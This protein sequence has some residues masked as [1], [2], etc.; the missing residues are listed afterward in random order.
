MNI[1]IVSKY[2]G[3]LYGAAI[4]WVVAFHVYAIDKADLSFG[5]AGGFLSWFATFVQNGSVGVDI[6]LFLSG[7]CL[8]FSFVK[9]ADPRRFWKKRLLRIFLPLWIIDG[10]YWFIRVVALGEGGGSVLACLEGFA[11]RMLLLR[12]WETGD[13]TCWYGSLIVVLY[14]LYPALHVF[15]FSPNA[16]SPLARCLALMAFFYFLC[17]TTRHCQPELYANVEIALTRIPVFVFGTYMGKHV[18]EGKL[19][20]GVAGV[21]GALA[22]SALWLGV[23]HYELID[24]KMLRRFFFGLGGV[25]FSYALCWIFAQIDGLAERLRARRRIKETAGDGMKGRPCA[26]LRFLGWVGAFSFELYVAHI[27]VNQV[28]R[29]LPS[30]TPGNGNIFPYF[31]IV[32]PISVA[33]AWLAYKLSGLA[34]TRLARPADKP[35]GARRT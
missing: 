24:D 12:F 22:L 15:V 30:F 10:L 21:V 28:Y 8:Y 4:L 3:P 13:G 18:Y 16:R 35:T 32:A 26:L 11:S 33:V 19:N 6:F 2:R 29:L 5:H 14:L 20:L 17:L 27:M 34:S 31:C 7:I 9:D 1:N 23:I 25:S